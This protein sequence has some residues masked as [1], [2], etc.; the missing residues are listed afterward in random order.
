MEVAMELDINGRRQALDG[1]WREESLLWVLREWLDL[2]GAKFGCGVGVCGAC[3]VLVDGQAVRSCQILAREVAGRRIT[4]VEGLARP[5]GRLHPLQ[6]AWLD[7]A[8]SQ[9]GYC[10]AGQIMSATALLATT[11]RPSPDQINEALAGN[12]CRCGTQQRIRLAV[13]RAAGTG[14]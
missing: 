7:E 3:T 1:A 4:T 8:V 13:Q 6:Q 2:V 10:Q 12:L 11:P 5:D 9:C 14:R